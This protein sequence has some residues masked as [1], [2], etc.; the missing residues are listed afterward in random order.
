MTSTSTIK[1]NDYVL[2][3]DFK[4]TKVIVKSRA[5][6]ESL[7]TAHYNFILCKPVG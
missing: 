7:P 5:T 1:S 2:I 6:C 3:I 4:E